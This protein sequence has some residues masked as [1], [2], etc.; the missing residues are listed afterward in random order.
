MKKFALVIF[1]S[2][3]FV[4]CISQNTIIKDDKKKWEKVNVNPDP[5]G[6]PWMAGGL[7]PLTEAEKQKVLNTPRLLIKQEKPGFMRRMFS[8]I[9]GDLPGVGA[10]GGPSKLNNAENNAFRPVFNQV[11]NCCS[12]A[13]GVGYNFTYEWNLMKGSSATSV[14]TQFPSHYTWNFLNQGKDYGSWYFDGWD[15]IIEN[16]CPTV[17][18]YGSMHAG[19][20]YTHWMSGY[21]KYKRAMQNRII[22]YRTIKVNTWEGINTLRRWMQDHARG[23]AAGGLA[24]FSALSSGVRMHNLP[25]GT[26]EAGKKV[27]TSWGSGGAHAMTFVGYNDDICWDYNND[28][29]YTNDIDINNDGVVDLKD[30]ERGALIVANTWGTGWGNGGFSYMMYNVCARTSDYGGL[31]N[32]NLVH[33]IDVKERRESDIKYALK[34]ELIHNSRNKINFSLGYNEDINATT[35]SYIKKFKMFRNLGGYHAM[36]GA[37][38]PSGEPFE[39]GLDL[40]EFE[41]KIKNYKGKFFLIIESSGGEGKVLNASIMDYN[42]NKEHKATIS[43]LKINRG[44]TVIP[45]NMLYGTEKILLAKN[46]IL[47]ESIE[48]E[49]ALTGEVTCSMSNETFTKTG[50]L[51]RDTDYTVENIPFGLTEEVTLTDNKTVRVIL[52]GKAK[53]NESADNCGVRILFK[54]NVFTG[55]RAEDV[56]GSKLTVSINFRD[57]YKTKYFDLE[58]LVVTTSN[59]WEL[60][61]TGLTGIYFGGWQCADVSGC[62]FKFEPYNSEV[63][64]NA[65]TSNIKPLKKGDIIDGNSDWYK[66]NNY[67]DQPNIDTDKYRDWRGKDAYIGVKIT[68]LDETY[69]GWFHCSVNSEG[70]EF[71]I[72]D[73]AY[74]TKP[75]APVPAGMSFESN[76]QYSSSEFNEDKYNN[77]GGVGNHIVVKLFNEEFTL[78]QNSVLNLNEHYTV[79]GLAEGLTPNVKL[80]ENNSLKIQ[81]SGRAKKHNKSD[82]LTFTI[83]FKDKLFKDVL[84][85]EITNTTK[86]LKINFLDEYKVVYKDVDDFVCNKTRNWN[87]F[88]INNKSSYGS[89]FDKSTNSLRFETYGKPTVCNENSRNL[90]PLEKGAVIDGNSKHWFGASGLANIPYVD[91]ETYQAWR[92]KEA[93]F[94]IVA[95]NNGLN[96][97]GWIRVA[98]SADGSEYTIKDWAYNEQPLLPITAGET[99]LITGPILNISD[100]NFIEPYSDNGTLEGLANVD[101][102]N[103]EFVLDPGTKLIKGTNFDVENLPAGIS[104]EI[105][106]KSKNKLNVKFEGTASNHTTDSNSDVVIKLKDN[107]FYESKAVDVKNSTFTLNLKFRGPWDIIYEDIIDINT[108][109]DATWNFFRVAFDGEFGAWYFKDIPS[110]KLESYKSYTIC[111][112]NTNNLK[113]LKQGDLIGNNSNGWY[114][115][116]KYPNQPDV[117]DNDFKT[118]EGKEGYIGFGIPHGD[119][120]HYGWMKLEVAADGSSYKI[121]EIAYNDQPFAPIMAG[122]K[123]SANQPAVEYLNSNFKESYE[124]NGEIAGK[125]RIVTYNDEFAL[126]VNDKFT[127]NN[128]Y[129]VENL[130][131]GLSLELTVVAKDTLEMAIKG[132]AANHNIDDIKE[133]KL[134]LKASAFKKNKAPKNPEKFYS[135]KLKGEYKV[136]YKD[137]DDIVCN[138]DNKWTKFDFMPEIGQIGAWCYMKDYKHY[139]KLELYDSKALCNSGTYNVNLLSEGV[140]LGETT[141]GWV[142]YDKFPNQHNIVSEDFIDYNGKTGYIGIESMDMGYKFYGWIKVQVAADGKSYSVLEYAYNEEPGA[143]IVTGAKT[144]VPVQ[145]IVRFNSDKQEV[146]VGGEISFTDESEYQP[147]SWQWSFPGS[148]ILQ[149]SIQNPKVVYNKPGVFD[150]TLKAANKDGATTLTQKAYI[151][152]IEAN[153]P[154]AD[155]SASQ[156]EVILNGKV[157]FQCRSVNIPNSWRWE[158]EGAEPSESTLE[159]PVVTY[160]KEGKFRVS[161]ICSNE[162]GTDKVVKQEYIIVKK[163]DGYCN[164]SE[165][166][167]KVFIS[168]VNIGDINNSSDGKGYS[169]FTSHSTKMEIGKTYPLNISVPLNWSYNECVIWIDWN[170]DKDFND[171]GEELKSVRN[172]QETGFVLNITVPENA[173]HGLTRMRIR[174]CYY[175][176]SEPCK[177][178]NGIGEVEDYSVYI[179]N[180]KPKVKFSSSKTYIAKGESVIYTDMSENNPT[181]W[182]WEFEG[183]HPATS[184][185]KNV[186]VTYNASGVYKVK[187]TVSNGDNSDVK[188]VESYITVTEIPEISEPLFTASNTQ[189]LGGTKVKFVN[190]TQFD[191]DNIYEWVFEGGTPK[192][193]NDIS[194]EITYNKQ[195]EYDVTLIVK[196]NGKKKTLTKDNLIIVK[197]SF[198]PVANFKS[199]AKVVLKGNRIKFTDLS[200]NIPTEWKWEFEGGTPATSAD[201]NPE[202]TYN[203]TGMFKV[204]LNVKNNLGSGVL[205]KIDYVKVEKFNA[206]G[207]CDA[208]N[209]YPDN[210]L[211]IKN[212]KLAEINNTTDIT[213]Y[214]NFTNLCAYLNK[215]KEYDMSITYGN[216]WSPNAVFVWV[217]WNQDKEFSND[218][219]IHFAQNSDGDGLEEFKVEVPSGAK[220]GYTVMRI[221]TAYSNDS[222]PCGTRKYAG[223]VEDYSICITEEGMTQFVDFNANNRD[224]DSGNSVFFSNLSDN[225]DSYAWEFEGGTPSVSSLKSP[226]VK[227]NSSG[228]YN[229]KLTVTKNGVTYSK[230]KTDYIH[231]S[232]NNSAPTDIAISKIT[233]SEDSEIGT[234]IGEISATDPDAGNTHT[235]TLYGDDH[236]KFKL[237][238]NKLKLNT[239]L[240]YETDSLYNINIMAVDNSGAEFSKSFVIKVTDV[241]ENHVPTNIIL[242]IAVSENAAIGTIIGAFATNDPDV[243]DSHA[244]SISKGDDAVFTIYENLLKLNAKLDYE[245]KSSY[246]LEITVTDKS[247][248]KF[249]KSFIIYVI[250]ADESSPSADNSGVILNSSDYSANDV[251]NNVLSSVNDNADNNFNVYPNPV[252]DVLTVSCENAKKLEIIDYSGKI[253]IRK[254]VDDQNSIE[255][256]VSELNDGFYLLRVTLINNKVINRKIIK[257]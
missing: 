190:E 166:G 31:Q 104:C 48:N 64:C 90:K 76:L 66:Y 171:E 205:E 169:D 123:V 225:A 24:N 13:S 114:K 208:R 119:M 242:S 75:D 47:N 9:T 214:S 253:M 2:T 88:H 69:Y 41:S 139:L 29:K 78:S 197:E 5:S 7:R 45:I 201:K 236:S 11:G 246:N 203:N 192:I 44:K 102:I 73:F 141:Q 53:N 100:K 120:W 180:N 106:V 110:L 86:E 179:V 93:Y 145:P 1:L 113:L 167:E 174:S 154:V 199:S 252:T 43:G 121:K 57:E 42:Y 40:Q 254:N 21:D 15:F 58:D 109:K 200:E 245:T 35:Y 51:I 134:T 54:D 155:F 235:F 72:M 186:S 85:S 238:G 181:E 10:S 97:Y 112:D 251:D 81:L 159:N 142:K 56:I 25:N 147:S 185:N 4:Y 61:K 161:L 130:P 257:K 178:S 20:D 234:V 148:E 77:S 115:Y 211:A 18:D 99:T 19:K 8:Y 70:T 223:E 187:L 220:S 55:N 144:Y 27:I 92:G 227:Y 184:S 17:K 89:W 129:S 152:V 59:T 240:D 168:K 62:N 182:S 224:V 248:G 216:H 133:F 195:G 138:R 65:N 30:S 249:V 71:R 33:I 6:D 255:F 247:G 103:E 49:G 229:V 156:T 212:V 37:N 158:F 146:F 108:N 244:Y 60:I 36:N 67:P 82:A 256:D 189:I 162:Y 228:N 217:D 26:E 98:V 237:D 143:P 175:E 151:K 101:A 52:K 221:R 63:V 131:S 74:C 183:G 213:E 250:D 160:K 173:K 170:G 118:W 176:N 222:K 188:E 206:S 96:C 16:G 32:S 12:Q 22:E 209:I 136:V 83:E 177:V 193:S 126:N 38:K 50:T 219:R 14:E 239:K 28:G 150:V 95:I 233:V 140:I 87:S 232:G 122:E 210:W 80:I 231:V 202:I 196:C 3:F 39:F 215:S 135:I 94:G 127:L 207:Y 117:W 194:P 191:T 105:T 68:N 132:T 34:V 198:K 218:E 128:Q 241:F 204:K 111:Y 226:I 230:E 243:S 137:I 165:N 84:A 46:N 125:S 164:A 153:V 79:T 163:L 172:S 116:D 124:N 91:S 23:D 107:V 149:S 157:N